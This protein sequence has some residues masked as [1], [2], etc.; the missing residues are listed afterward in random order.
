MFNFTGFYINLTSTEYGTHLKTAFLDG[1]DFPSEFDLL[2]KNLCHV[3]Q[4]MTSGLDIKLGS[5]VKDFLSSTTPPAQ[6]QLL[7]YRK[8][9]R[10]LLLVL[11]A[12]Q[13]F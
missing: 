1:R 13:A 5:V 3:E 8:Q 7:C 11:K 2:L 6:L 9:K 4:N 12:T 10:I